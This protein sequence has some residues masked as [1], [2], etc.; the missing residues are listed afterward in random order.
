[1]PVRESAGWLI[2]VEG[3]VVGAVTG[4]VGAD[5]GF[6][7]VPALVLLGGLGME[8]AVGTSLVV[9]AMKSFAAF[10]GFAGHTPIDWSLA[11]VISLAAVAGS[12]GG[13]LLAHRLSPATL[14]QAVGWFVVA[15]ALC[16]T[17]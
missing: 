14:R 11:V 8:V 15:M 1:A 10:A 6:L 9:I 7:V 2:G 5:G 16:I 13:S 3:L 17:T 12:V 4:M